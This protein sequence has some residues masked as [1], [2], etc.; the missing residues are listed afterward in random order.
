M[1][2]RGPFRI[3][4]RDAVTTIIQTDENFAPLRDRQGAALARRLLAG[5]VQDVA[6]D[7]DVKTEFTFLERIAA[8]D[9]FTIVR[10][11]FPHPLCGPTSAQPRLDYAGVFDRW[12]TRFRLIGVDPT[13]VRGE[14]RLRRGA[15]PAGEQVSALERLEH[16]LATWVDALERHGYVP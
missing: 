10:E 4:R 13:T 7:I 15:A 2:T 16:H 3:E 6:I 1:P 9:L 11:Y 12:D 8:R 5:R 14:A